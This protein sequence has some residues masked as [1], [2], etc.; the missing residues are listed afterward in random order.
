MKTSIR[1]RLL[2]S[3]LLVSFAT[4]CAA[5]G[6]PNIVWSIPDAA[7]AV[8]FSPD[9]QFV[10]HA[11]G[12]LFIRIRRAT[13]GVVV[14]SIRDRSTINALAYSPDGTRILDGR[15]N[16]TSFNATVFRIADGV[17]IFKLAGHSNATRAVAWSPNGT[18]IA[19]G[20]D[21]RTAKLWRASDGSLV[22]TIKD[23]SH[24]RALAFSPNGL[25]LADGDDFAVK[26]W[27]VADGALLHTLTG[28]SSSVVSVAFSPDGTQV[29]G[30]SLDGSIRS[31]NTTSWSRIR[32]LSLLGS[33]TSIAYSADGFSLLAGNDEVSPQPEH[34]TLRF[35]RVSD[36]AELRFY[37]QET[38]TYVYSVAASPLKTT[39]A[40]SRQ[41]DGVVGVASNP[42]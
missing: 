30:A 9:G 31:W 40:Y 24:V 39:Y 23:G 3:F 37:D 8:V 21:D 29:S 5:Q 2:G 13:D 7:G 41:L 32:F 12:G 1:F 38:G 18:I 35:Y 11:A 26:I 27:R 33:V 28:P 36:G 42:F 17:A 25:L 15:T 34:G 22:R 6:P 4:I 14:R 10:T 20:G 16:G 19:T